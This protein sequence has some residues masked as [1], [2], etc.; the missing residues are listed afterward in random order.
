MCHIRGNR[1][2]SAFGTEINEQRS[3]HRVFYY[4]E[5]T[6][7]RADVSEFTDSTMKRVGESAG[8]WKPFTWIFPR[9]WNQGCFDIALVCSIDPLDALDE[10]NR[11][12]KIGLEFF[13]VTVSQSHELKLHLL[14]SI[15]NEL[16][17]LGH[18]LNDNVRFTAIVPKDTYA[19]FNFKI[20]QGNL[21]MIQVETF[22]AHL[23]DGV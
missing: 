2:I 15:I 18:E 1:V 13:Q 3:V 12:L 21:R 11:R 5:S 6:K 14:H 8:D 9:K 22:V 16:T 4:K 7:N 17:S 23:K 10:T 19:D 20:P